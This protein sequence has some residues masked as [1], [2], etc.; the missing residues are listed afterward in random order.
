MRRLAP[1]IDFSI[2]PISIDEDSEFAYGNGAIDF[3]YTYLEVGLNIYFFKPGKGLYG[4]ISYGR[5]SLFYDFTDYYN[6]AT[7]AEGGV[8]RLDV[9]LNMLNFKLG[10]KLGKYVYFRPEIGIALANVQEDIRYTIQYPR[11]LIRRS[12][13]KKFL[14]CSLG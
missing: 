6:E 7:D 14:T 5:P 11:W 2:I 10:A 4:N 8:G 13:L 3:R 12:G 9:A 1:T